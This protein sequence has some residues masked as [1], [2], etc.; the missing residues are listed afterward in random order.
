MSVKKSFSKRLKTT[1]KEQST[2]DNYSVVDLQKIRKITKQIMEL[3][4]KI[5]LL[6]LEKIM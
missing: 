5:M 4:E 1:L 6:K 3:E 2:T